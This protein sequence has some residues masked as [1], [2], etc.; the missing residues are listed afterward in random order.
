M[1]A[2][3]QSSASFA[4]ALLAARGPLVGPSIVLAQK[5]DAWVGSWKAN[6]AK[7]TYVGRPGGTPTSD[8]MR[9][10]D[11]GGG[12]FKFTFDGVDE[13][14]PFHSQWT[15]KSDGVDVPLPR[16]PA[17]ESEE[18]HCRPAYRRSYLRDPREGRWPADRH[19]PQHHL[20][21]RE[22]NDERDNS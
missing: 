6:I 9:I 2:A 19:D 22:N 1:T 17:A 4:V 7:S 5:P 12:V 10:E 3:S 21:R 18:H 11:V 15:G 14:G 8:A 20:G 16:D 13:R